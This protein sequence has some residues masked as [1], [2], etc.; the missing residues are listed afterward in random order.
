MILVNLKLVWSFDGQKKTKTLNSLLL[1][2]QGSKGT[3]T[4]DFNGNQNQIPMV[5][6]W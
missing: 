5:N 6:S 1:S 2:T 3:S 4:Y